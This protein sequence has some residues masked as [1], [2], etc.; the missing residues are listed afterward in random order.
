MMMA[1]MNTTYFAHSANTTGECHFLSQHLEGVAGLAR[2]FA[3]AAPWADEAR[4]AGLLHDLGKYADR[5]Q[6]RLRGEDSGLDHWSQGAWLALSKYQAVTA[7]LAVQGHHVGLQRGSPQAMLGCAPAQRMLDFS[8][9]HREIADSIIDIRRTITGS[10]RS[11][12]DYAVTVHR[13][14]LPAGVELVTP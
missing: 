10:P 1:D 7:A 3:D 9:H 8:T 14:R 13:D 4:L 12:S 6:A 2:R 11:F 5:F